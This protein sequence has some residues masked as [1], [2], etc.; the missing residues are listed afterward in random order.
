M[1]PPRPASPQVRKEHSFAR[2]VDPSRDLK[3]ARLAIFA[4]TGS[5]STQEPM[6]AAF[7]LAACAAVCVSSSMNEAPNICNCE[8]DRQ[9]HRTRLCRNTSARPDGLCEG[10]RLHADRE[11]VDD[12]ETLIQLRQLQRADA[13]R[14]RSEERRVGKECRSRR[15]WEPS[16]RE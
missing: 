5:L 15:T 9:C 2:P 14:V 6:I 12:I 13:A 3:C 16:K 8:G 10:C 1:S 4:P 11:T 7:Y